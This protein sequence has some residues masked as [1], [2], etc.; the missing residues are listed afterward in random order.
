MP[1]LSP[2]GRRRA[3]LG[4]EQLP[5]GSREGK[6]V[7]CWPPLCGFFCSQV[8]LSRNKEAACCIYPPCL[9]RVAEWRFFQV[10]L[11]TWYLR[12]D[13]AVHGA[14]DAGH[15]F[16]MMWLDIRR[17]FCP[18]SSDPCGSADWLEPRDP[19]LPHVYGQRVSQQPFI[20]LFCFLAKYESSTYA[21]PN[22]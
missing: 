20:A 22:A 9:G 16:S 12:L 10:L 15:H 7:M 19:S 21:P 5:L 17:G 1:L 8:S 18:F 14:R 3:V 2:R 4:E 11:L 13:A 6:A